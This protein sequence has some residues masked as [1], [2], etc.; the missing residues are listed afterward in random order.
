MKNIILLLYLLPFLCS[1][2]NYRGQNTVADGNKVRVETWNYGSFSSPGNWTTD[3]VW[4]SLGYA[5]EFNWF[6]GAEVT[7]PQ[8]SH[9]DVKFIDGEWRAH[10][11]SDGVIS[12]GGETA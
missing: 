4:N 6:V 3:F 5:Y 9:P 1:A 12:N 11:I 7:V 10:V 2:Q 8:G